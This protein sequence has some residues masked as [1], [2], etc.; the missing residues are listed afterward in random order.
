MVSAI[1][2]LVISLGAILAG[3]GYVKNARRM[4]AFA[5]V[6]GKVLSRGVKAI[7]GGVRE[8]RYGKGGGYMPD[9][10]YSYAV[11]G[12]EYE[13]DKVS[14]AFKGLKRE[15]AQQ[16]ADAFPADPDVFYNPD[17]PSEAYLT[18]HTPAIGRWFIAGGV[19]GVLMALVVLLG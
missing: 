3:W 6:Q 12:R 18:T 7:P 16:A 2:L 15:L 11:D 8:G 5:T 1:V 10:R 19:V 9:I 13:S 17:E 14:Y 4:R